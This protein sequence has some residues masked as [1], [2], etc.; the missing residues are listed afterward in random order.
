MMM[1]LSRFA[2][3]PVRR[4]LFVCALSY[5]A[6][7]YLAELSV[8]P[9]LEILIFCVLF[10]TL[11]VLRLRHRKSALIFTVALFLIL[12]NWRAGQQ[13][14]V[15][16]VATSPGVLIEGTVSR[17]ESDYRVY[18]GD[19]LIDGSTRIK[20]DVAVTL[21]LE[22][23][24]E[25]EAPSVGIGQTII[26]TGRLF[27]QEGKRNP[28]G[29]DWRINALSK[30][31][32]LSGY[33]LPGWEVS[34]DEAFSIIEAFRKTNQQLSNRIQSLFGEHAPLYQ[35]IVLGNK[36]ELD[37]KLM[38]AMRL[39]GIVHILTISGMHMS[40]IA[41]ALRYV[42]SKLK[43]RR[44]LR[45]M[46]HAVLLGGF[47]CL[48][49]FS[50]GTIRAYIMAM[51]REMASLTGRKYDPLT[52]LGTAALI[53]ALACPIWALSASFQFSFL[54][55]LG[56]LLLYK[57]FSEPIHAIKKCPNWLKRIAGFAV[58]TFSAQLV[59]V[60]M[61]LMLYG[62]VPLLAM[63]M[64]LISGMFVPVIMLFGWS[65]LLLSACFPQ[66][67]YLLAQSVGGFTSML[68]RMCVFLS[69]LPWGILRLPS[70]YSISLLLVIALM[71]VVSKQ[72][73]VA[74]GRRMISVVFCVILIFLYLPRFNPSTGYVQLDV[75]QGDGAIIRSGRK[76]VLIDVGPE[77]EYA[78]LHYL[79]H[80]GLSVEL[81]ILSHAD[82]D[83]AGA[84]NILLDSEIQVSRVAM[85]EGACDDIG[86]Q[87]VTDAFVKAA[88][89][90]I[91]IEYYEEGDEIHADKL[92]FSVL[93]PH[94]SMT[95]SNERSL[96]LY[97]VIDGMRLLTLGDLPEDCE[98]EQVPQCDIL[99]VA[100]HGSRYA[101][102]QTLI[103]KASPQVAVISVGRNSYG[104]PTDRVLDDLYSIGAEVYRTDRSGCVTIK[105]SAKGCIVE[106]FVK[107]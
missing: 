21:M 92:V 78:M 17:L 77:D 91:A 38:H 36:D 20:R 27:A 75:G 59:A 104:H 51:I 58:L 6:G 8:I 70:P 100:H 99:K 23:E 16:D 73:Y 74:K 40:L 1:E 18:L 55:V 66:T 28:G 97:T 86:S 9:D 76:A 39:T 24:T 62:Y 80:E 13:L 34:G 69:E 48:T 7:I 25:G 87:A 44:R 88:E 60:P 19:V 37:T 43:F 71:F 81:V 102:S 46:V 45:F 83:H 68:E 95:G 30:G 26:G 41:Q 49:G 65:C 52:S 106:T 29:V 101:T 42:T 107:R 93:S 57:Q 61:Q 22:E 31:Y 32:D 5:L 3:A 94:A 84:L 63:P 11:S 103:K 2:S 96:V 90:G 85:P 54:V 79:R 12:G 72:V 67:A 47:T 105:N 35:A 56:I 14:Q 50:L 53:M 82:E 89:E 64:N 98:M 10:L 4:K 15:K 33:I